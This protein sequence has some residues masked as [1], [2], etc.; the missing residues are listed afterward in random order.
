MQTVY[1]K[2]VKTVYLKVVKTVYLKVVK[3]VYLKVVKTVYLK[4]V[5]SFCHQDSLLGAWSQG[6]AGS[7]VGVANAVGGEIFGEYQVEVGGRMIEDTLHQQYSCADNNVD[8]IQVDWTKLII[9]VWF[10]FNKNVNELI[11]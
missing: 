4:V 7:A 9:V 2:V 3:A 1:L 8:V 5:K 11:A 10:M 6:S